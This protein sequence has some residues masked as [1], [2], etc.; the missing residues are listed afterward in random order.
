MESLKVAK[1]GEKMIVIVPFDDYRYG[2]YVMLKPRGIDIK[3][4]VTVV[5]S[6]DR[7]LVIIPKDYHR[8]FRHRSEVYLRKWEKAKI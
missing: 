7:K 6:G 3:L 8:F 2:D 1:M 5:K 4:F